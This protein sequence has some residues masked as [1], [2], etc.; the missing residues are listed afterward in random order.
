MKRIAMLAVLDLTLVAFTLTGCGGSSGFGKHSHLDEEYFTTENA[1]TTNSVTSEQDT[2]N[3]ADDS[4]YESSTPASP[5]YESSAPAS[6]SYQTDDAS[7]PTYEG[8]DAE[9]DSTSSSDY[10]YYYGNKNDRKSI[11][12]DARDYEPGE[13]SE[14]Y[15]KPAPDPRYASAALMLDYR[16]R[17]YSSD[18]V[19]LE[20]VLTDVFDEGNKIQV[21]FTKSPYP[22]SG[23]DLGATYTGWLQEIDAQNYV[24]MDGYYVYA[25][26]FMDLWEDGSRHE[27]TFFLKFSFGSRDEKGE[28]CTSKIGLLGDTLYVQ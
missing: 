14:N 22:L 2:T 7:S 27:D 5:S 26:P 23:I 18:E 21:V 9:S 15:S 13:G 16:G 6:P 4:S 28:F 8:G 17:T 25:V 10:T 12:Q 3:A 24:M 1:G 20:F 19:D 11:I